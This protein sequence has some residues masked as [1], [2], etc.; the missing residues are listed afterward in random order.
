MWHHHRD[1]RANSAAGSAEPARGR[2]IPSRDPAPPPL[3]AHAPSFGYTGYEA[4][5]DREGETPGRK[6]ANSLSKFFGRHHHKDEHDEHEV[7]AK[8]P[9]EAGALSTVPPVSDGHLR[10][11]PL[12]TSPSLPSPSS[13][14][15]LFSRAARQ[16]RKSAGSAS[17]RP[18]LPPPSLS[19][20]QR[21][22]S[23]PPASSPVD[24]TGY[25]S[26]APTFGSGRTGSLPGE[27][28]EDES[29][30]PASFGPQSSSRSGAE[31]A[32]EPTT[33]TALLAANAQLDHPLFK[34]NFSFRQLQRLERAAHRVEKHDRKE[35]RKGTRGAE[36]KIA[37]GVLE[38]L[39]TER[40]NKKR[41]RGQGGGNRGRS[42]SRSRSRSRG[43]GGG[44]TDGEAGDLLEG[45]TS[46]LGG[47]A[48]QL[49]SDLEHRLGG[50]APIR[51]PPTSFQS[52]QPSTATALDNHAEPVSRPE[53]KSG[54][55]GREL[56]A[57]VGGAAAV[58][59]LVGAGY[60]W[61]RHHHD[62]GSHRGTDGAAREGRERLSGERGTERGE[63]PLSLRHFS[64][65]FL[66]LR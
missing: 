32:A 18:P 36:I 60:E 44:I 57:G 43:G 37:M 49:E 7:R 12:K 17:T 53:S 20:R 8:L 38:I 48:R 34:A 65:V 54:V 4:E 2:P 23:V 10:A 30:R 35:V 63:F 28:R 9:L 26:R 5:H 50:G 46:G 15:G 1:R 27:P 41:L 24:R 6:R 56:V 59:G 66:L 61:W 39:E 42:R 13:E 62:A 3:S 52:R 19:S 55:S 47:L 45:F 21:S 40:R 51:P 29:T 16:R 25:E 14:S 33:T 58:V 64:V 31:E 22:A 11:D